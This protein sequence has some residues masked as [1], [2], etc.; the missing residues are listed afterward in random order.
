[1][2]FYLDGKDL[3]LDLAVGGDHLTDLILGVFKLRC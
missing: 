2:I 3:L 1:M